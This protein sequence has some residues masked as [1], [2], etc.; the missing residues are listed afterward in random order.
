M[1]A[2]WKRS[3]DSSWRQNEAFA[4]QY[5]ACEK[6]LGLDRDKANVYGNGIA[7]GHPVGATG[8]RLIVT[9]LYGMRAGGLDLGIASLC[10]GGGMGFA[11]LV[12]GIR[13]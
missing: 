1:P 4:A 13:P 11:V 3:R 5:L 12:E 2:T 8:C 7:L 9:L 6:V 10:A